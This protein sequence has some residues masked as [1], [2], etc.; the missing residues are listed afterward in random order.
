MWYQNTGY[1]ITDY[2]I[3]DYGIT[4]YGIR[5]WSQ[6]NNWLEFFFASLLCLFVIF[7]SFSH[8]FSFL[9]FFLQILN[10]IY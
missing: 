9:I 8:S 5:V 1:G 2:G 3:T 7:V 6:S 10:A 4:D